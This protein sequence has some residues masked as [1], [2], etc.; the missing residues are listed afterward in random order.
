[1]ARPYNLYVVKALFGESCE[2]QSTHLKISMFENYLENVE[3]EPLISEQN[4]NM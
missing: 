1:M 4:T 2:I 3:I